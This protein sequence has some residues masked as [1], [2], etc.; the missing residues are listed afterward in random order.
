MYYIKLEKEINKMPRLTQF[1]ATAMAITFIL[2]AVVGKSIAGESLPENK[3][4]PTVEGGVDY[5]IDYMHSGDN[6]PIDLKKIENIIDF[7]GSPDKD[8]SSYSPRKWGR[9]TPIYQE[10]VID[11]EFS[12]LLKYTMNPDIPTQVFRPSSLRYSY[13]KDIN[14]EKKDLPSLWKHS[15]KLDKPVVIRGTEHEMITPDT[16]TGAYYT[17]DMK[18]V[19]ILFRHK[20]RRALISISLQ[21]EPS[22]VGKK[23]AVLGHDE[24]WNYFYSGINGLTKKG[25]GWASSYIYRSF[26][27]SVYYE[28]ESGKPGLSYGM[29]KWL[30]AGWAGMNMVKKEHLITGI[31]RFVRDFKFVIENPKLPSPEELSR[32]FS[33]IQNRPVEEMRKE[34]GKYIE[35]IVKEYGSGDMLSRSEFSELIKSGDYLSKMKKEELMSILV[36]QYMKKT[37]GKEFKGTLFLE[38]P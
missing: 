28:K 32:T 25:L 26:S 2:T 15:E 19:L 30:R 16:N 8:R 5:L 1:V 12:S 20:G 18:R 23:G 37:L 13:W 11:T 9:A 14:G 29:F 3:I 17:Y 33:D 4:T 6:K 10:F 22:E 31:Q 24:D 27:I 21:S 35:N 36:V 7:V 38:K 34:A